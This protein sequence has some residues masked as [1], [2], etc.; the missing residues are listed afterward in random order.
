[1][2]RFSLFSPVFFPLLFSSFSPFPFLIFLFSLFFSCSMKARYALFS[3]NR[4]SNYGRKISYVG[5]RSILPPLFFPFIPF[6]SI[7]LVF[8]NLLLLG[9]TKKIFHTMIVVERT[10]RARNQLSLDK[11]NCQALPRVKRE[12]K[13]QDN[14]YIHRREK[15]GRQRSE[16]SKANR[17]GS[18]RDT[19]LITRP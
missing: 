8:P 16:T 18:G 11:I 14:R 7:L 15:Q 17:K 12:Y 13:Q 3:R 4:I 2:K 19:G 9:F 10:S 6:C 5:Y 1:M